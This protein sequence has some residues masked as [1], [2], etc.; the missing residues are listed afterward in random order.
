[1]QAQ[2]TIWSVE[3]THPSEPRQERLPSI[4]AYLTSGRYTPEIQITYL[5]VWETETNLIYELKTDVSD[6]N[7]PMI[8]ILEQNHWLSDLPVTFMTL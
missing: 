3:L 8:L 5:S 4:L 6:M 2:R 7:E 1:M